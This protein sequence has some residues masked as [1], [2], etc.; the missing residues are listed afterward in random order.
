MI[1][2]SSRYELYYLLS[3]LRRE[4]SQNQLTSEP[5]S[6]NILPGTS[7]YGIFNSDI[8]YILNKNSQQFWNDVKVNFIQKEKQDAMDMLE[9]IISN[10]SSNNI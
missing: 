10:Y 2:L 3:F 8:K 5:V 9:G 1:N 4:E 6:Q 7:E